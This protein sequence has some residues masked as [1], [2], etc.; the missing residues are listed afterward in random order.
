MKECNIIVEDI[1]IWFEG[2]RYRKYLVLS[3]TPLTLMP[4]SEK[5]HL[6]CD[7]QDKS[8]NDIDVQKQ[9]FITYHTSLLFGEGVHHSVSLTSSHSQRFFQENCSVLDQ[10]Y[11]TFCTSLLGKE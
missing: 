8:Y 4:L 5:E 3:Y 6:I 9:Q 1:L 10:S 7:G 11:P 2:Q